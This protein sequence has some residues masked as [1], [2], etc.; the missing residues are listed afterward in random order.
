MEHFRSFLGLPL[1]LII[2]WLLSGDKRKVSFRIIIWGIGLQVV[3]AFL[4][5]K[6][7][8][9]REF[10]FILG[11]VFNRVVNFSDEGAKFL[12]GGVFLG[13]SEKGP[14]G[15][16]QV[17]D[18]GRESF[19]DLGQVMISFGPTFAFKV[20]PS[21][22]FFAS[23]TSIFYHLGF[24]QRVVQAMAWVMAR[25]MGVSGAESVNAAANIFIGMSDAPLLVRPYISGMT[26]SELAALMTT[27]FATIAG[28][29]LAAYISFGMDA[30][31]LLAASVMSAPAALVTAK[32]IFPETGVPQTKGKVSLKVEKETVN[33]I[34]AA[35]QGA[36]A[37]L[38]IALNIGAMLIAFIAL[39]ALI[40]Y[41]LGLAGA[42]LSMILGYVFAPIAFILGIPLSELLQVGQ[43]LGTKVS[44]NEF[45]A[46]VELSALKGELSERSFIICTYA[47]CGFANFSS[48]GMQ[49]G[50]IGGIAPERKSDLAKL[51][52][53]AMIGGA[54]ASWITASIA[55]LLIA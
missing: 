16:L 50:C 41:I 33:V 24:L 20:L 38:K 11:E 10:F 35:A 37:G 39:I 2:A 28:S 55:G 9:G 6:T 43:L 21:I 42:S 29:V 1:L 22:I 44:I 31:H 51:G 30:G 52:L 49:I 45:V 17:W 13:V 46:F 25:T 3:F 8:P 54:L 36:A 27:G 19:V 18:A 34:D 32:L 15:P 4:I 26:M 14:I 5:L 23:L 7:T 40:N 47:L 53:K 48:I 12:F